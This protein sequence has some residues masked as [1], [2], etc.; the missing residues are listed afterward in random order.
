MRSAAAPP[1]QSAFDLVPAHPPDQLTAGARLRQAAEA[2][3][4]FLARGQPVTPVMLRQAMTEAFGAT[5]A[6]GAWAWKDTYEALEAAQVLFLRRFLPT[7][8]K[9]ASG[10]RDLL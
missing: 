2:L 7:M 8:R 5:D 3:V 9:R 4:G 10:P 6:E 1:A